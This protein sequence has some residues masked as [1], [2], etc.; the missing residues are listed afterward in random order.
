MASHP[1][2]Q[3]NQ[4]ILQMAGL[5]MQHLQAGQFPEATALYRRILI[6]NP[7]HSDALHFLGVMALQEGR[8]EDSAGLIEQAIAINP[9]DVNALNNLGQAYESLQRLDDATDLYHRVLQRVPG[10]DGALTNLGNALAGKGDYLEAVQCYQRALEINKN[11]PEIHSNLGD[12]YQEQGFLDEAIASY[13]KALSIYPDFFEVLISL[14]NA[15]LEQGL[16]EEAVVNHQKAAD[17]NPHSAEAHSHLG[18]TLMTMGRLGEAF[19][20]FRRAVAIEP[21]NDL[22]WDGMAGTLKTLSFPSIDDTLLADLSRLI[23]MPKVRPSNVTRPIISALRHHPKFS[24]ILEL[25]GSGKPEVEIAYEDLAEQLSAI[26]LFLRILGLSPIDDL[27]IERMLTVMRRALLKETLAENNGEGNLLFS[28]ALAL[29]CFANEYIFFET[30]EE[31]ETIEQLHR[32]IAA[33]VEKERDVPPSLVTALGAYRALYD[34]PWAQ[35]LSE[36][37]WTGPITDVIKRQ[38][39]EPLEEQS[40]RSQFPRL[41][42]IQDGVSQLVRQQYEENPYPRWVET[43]ISDKGNDIRTVLERTLLHL[44]IGDYQSPE[45][46]EI[47]I[48]GCGTGQHALGTATRF[49]N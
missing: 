35:E 29:Q 48:A 4:T 6:S 15:L 36:R 25:A 49:S 47:L 8:A 46:P 31:K 33:L 38:I 42:P 34:F 16:L 45:N 20:S 11:D 18:C 40:L 32:Q 21:R 44:E 14:G 41:T 39:S 37:E 22:F 24:Q 1:P 28:T 5:A 27:E 30:D 23:E 12:V 26:P 17:I 2:E 10:H 13:Q 3:N 19:T 9:E 43:S 7:N